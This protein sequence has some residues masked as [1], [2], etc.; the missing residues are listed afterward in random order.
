MPEDWVVRD[1]GELFSRTCPVKAHEH[2]Q[3]PECICTEPKPWTPNIYQSEIKAERH[4]HYWSYCAKVKD[5][6]V[7][8]EWEL[9]L[10]YKK[11]GGWLSW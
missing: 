2:L 11:T 1:G 9:I 4:P 10:P 7:H 5:L 3:V 8:E 6:M